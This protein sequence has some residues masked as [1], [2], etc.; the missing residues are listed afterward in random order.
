MLEGLYIMSQ[1]ELERGKMLAKVVEKQLTQQ[2]AGV[3]LGLS[4]RHIKRLVKGYRSEGLPS[5]ISKRR[6]SK[7]H[8]QLSAEHKEQV[9]AIMLERYADFGPTFAA[10]KLR[11]CHE[12]SVSKETLR[13]WMQEWGLWKTKR[14][15]RA[16]LHPQRE[17]RSQFGEL[18]QLD[19]SPHDWFEGRGDKC[20]LLVLIDDA[21]SQL[22]GLRFEASETTHGYFQVVRRYLEKEGMPSAF[23]SDKYG[24]FRVNAVDAKS[25][26]G[27]TQFGRVCRTLGIELICAHSPQAKGRVERVNQTLQDRLVK[28]L[29]LAQISDRESAN[30]FL[31]SYMK[32]HNQRF[33][34]M[35]RES[36]NAHRQWVLGGKVTDRLFSLRSQRI[37]TKNLE[38]NYHTKIYQIQTQTKGYRLRGAK[39]DVYENAAGLVT[40]VYQEQVLS[41]QCFTK[42]LRPAPIADAKMLT[43]KLDNLGKIKHKPVSTHPWRR[44]AY[45]KAPTAVAAWVG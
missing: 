15:S 44:T 33:A 21:T 3:L 29:R 41:H 39:V 27:E 10:E 18:V 20:T 36:Q 12:L 6:G 37:L 8:H 45:K 4:V 31:P 7:G 35:P 2:A 22:L 26:T 32:L 13:Q 14:Q 40:I 24:V 5:L 11:T 34:V 43:T 25:G 19:G 42:A 17:R 38:L 30:A 23:Y 16:V 1:L 28:E 9:K